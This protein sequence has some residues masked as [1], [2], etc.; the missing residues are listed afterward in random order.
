MKKLLWTAFWMYQIVGCFVAV[1]Y[2]EEIQA[3]FYVVK[4]ATEG[5]L[6]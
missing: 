2:W 3:Y 6:S 4:R 1:Y 5:I